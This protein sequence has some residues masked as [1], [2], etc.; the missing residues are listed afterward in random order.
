M[1]LMLVM[2]SVQYINSEI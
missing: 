1:S 2:L